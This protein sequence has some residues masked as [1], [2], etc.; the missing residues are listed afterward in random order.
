VDMSVDLT[1]AG[2]TSGQF[3]RWLEHYLI[4]VK[5]HVSGGYP[6]MPSKPGKRSLLFV[7]PPTVAATD[8]EA[9]L[10]IMGR[11]LLNE[12]ELQRATLEV[13][14]IAAAPAKNGSVRVYLKGLFVAIDLFED[15]L[16]Q[17]TF[18]WPE[19]MPQ[20]LH[21]H[22]GWL[23]ATYAVVQADIAAFIEALPAPYE[24]S[25]I[26]WLAPNDLQPYGVFYT[27]WYPNP[28]GSLY[29]V[30]EIRV[31]RWRIDLTSVTTYCP[32][33]RFDRPP[34]DVDVNTREGLAD[35]L[36]YFQ[37]PVDEEIVRQ[38]ASLGQQVLEIVNRYKST[39]QESPVEKAAVQ[40]DQ[41]AVPDQL[42]KFTVPSKLQV[43]RFYR[44]YNPFTAQRI[45]DKLPEIYASFQQD[46]RYDADSWQL[47]YIAPKVEM[48]PTTL[49]RYLNCF[50]DFGTEEINGVPFPPD[51]RRKPR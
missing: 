4:S 35:A 43:K 36:N 39:V 46:S 30:M 25:H 8:D 21:E 5:P 40:I 28:D 48:T 34:S 11:I 45:A 41:P 22:P 14:R 13:V 26:D 15:L 51:R 2:M 44:D 1:L 27:L 3:I 33:Y 10:I 9:S 32:T 7:D 38:Q 37:S 29:P 49:G 20:L 24:S 47:K 18:E 42:A 50:R 16:S 12:E 17:I 6:I 19:T 23:Q 31:R